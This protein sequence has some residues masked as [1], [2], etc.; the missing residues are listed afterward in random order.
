MLTNKKETVHIDGSR[1]CC[2]DNTCDDDN[3]WGHDED[4]DDYHARDS[5]DDDDDDCGV[6]GTISFN[7]TGMCFKI[8]FICLSDYSFSKEKYNGIDN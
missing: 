5:D 6:R 4:D 3:W 8:Q 1:L 2:N 7:H